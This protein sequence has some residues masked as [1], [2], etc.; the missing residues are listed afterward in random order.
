MKTVFDN[1]MVAHVWANRSQARGRSSNG[2]LYFE[3]DTIYSYGRH[4][5]IARHVDGVVLFTIKG[6]SPTTECHKSR[7]LSACSHK[8]VFH[9]T[10]LTTGRKEH[11]ADYKA[12]I[13]DAIRAC[14]KARTNKPW[15]LQQL[16][17][18]VSEA[19]Q[20]A[21]N[22]DLKTRFALPNEQELIEEC[23]KI[24]ARNK[25]REARRARKLQKQREEREAR[26][27]EYFAK[28]EQLLEEWVDGE[29][30]SCPYEY[31]F[32]IRL[33]IKGNEL[34]TSRGA[35]VP[36]DH[37]VK[38]FRVLKQLRERGETYQRNGHT[39]H[40]GHFALDSFSD[41]IVRAGCHA[42]EWTEIER[43]ANLVGVN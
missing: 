4:F 31:G 21:E 25:A 29:R 38:C 20:Y 27:R 32:K 17:E 41:G 7:V 22:F 42:V 43:I 33:R 8:Q 34:Q 35:S 18:L 39:I 24:D 2:H 19:N 6:Y 15:R 16:Q 28:Q 1:D 40:L 12:R 23:R 14:V 26:Q 5:P 3:G 37:A 30:D 10:D 11:L 13:A 9:V 36:L